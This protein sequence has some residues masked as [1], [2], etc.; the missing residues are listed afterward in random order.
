M[1]RIIVFWHWQIVLYCPRL[2]YIIPP[3]LY[4][5]VLYTVEYIGIH[6]VSLCH[7]ITPA[8]NITL[9]DEYL[10]NVLWP[11][12]CTYSLYCVLCH[13]FVSTIG[14]FKAFPVGVTLIYCTATSLLRPCNMQMLRFSPNSKA[15]PIRYLHT[16]ILHTWDKN[17]RHGQCYVRYTCTV[18]KAIPPNQ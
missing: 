5:T 13:V 17:S 9:N 15:S 14:M 7:I 2:M 10:A 1:H 6:V 4:Y 12:H 8:L 16:K 11:V 18:N 3:I